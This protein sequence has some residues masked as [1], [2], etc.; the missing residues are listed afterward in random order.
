MT[1]ASTVMSNL[2]KESW[3]SA[4]RVGAWAR[5]LA[6][7]LAV[8]VAGCLHAPPGTVPLDEGLDASA[9]D[10]LSTEAPNCPAT[11]PTRGLGDS[12]TARCSRACARDAALAINALFVAARSEAEKERIIAE[13][14][15]VVV[16]VSKAPR[17]DG[18]TTSDDSSPDAAREL[19]RLLLEMSQ[20]SS[21][22]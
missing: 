22:K 11:A 2:R 10:S 18:S 19:S 3:I 9:A 5:R 4:W 14:P 15:G 6:C 8:P 21:P 7:V 20:D 17:P 13:Y 12:A 1:A 16:I